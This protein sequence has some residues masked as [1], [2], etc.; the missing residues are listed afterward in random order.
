MEGQKNDASRM[1]R[2]KPK[3]LASNHPITYSTLV[4]I[5]CSK[6]NNFFNYYHKLHAA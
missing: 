3:F 5:C 1:Q 4:K 6:Y 2:W